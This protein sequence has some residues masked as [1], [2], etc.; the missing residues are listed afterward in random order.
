MEENVLFWKDYFDLD[1]KRVSHHEEEFKASVNRSS[2][3]SL[4]LSEVHF[5]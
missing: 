5:P 2:E 3:V 1:N 4:S